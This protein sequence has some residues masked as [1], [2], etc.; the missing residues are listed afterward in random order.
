MRQLGKLP[1]SGN[2]PLDSAMAL[3]TSSPEVIKAVL[4]GILTGPVCP[5]AEER[6]AI[7]APTL[8]IAHRRDLIHPFG[9][10]ENLVDQLPDARLLSATSLLELRITP[11]RLTGEIAEFLDA[12][13][14][15]SPQLAAS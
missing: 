11:D 9:D 15:D 7:T 10:A 13:W 1:A 4:H 3:L 14:S 6:R 5:T 12:A 2:D 8:V